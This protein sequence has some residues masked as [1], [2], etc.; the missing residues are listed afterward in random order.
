MRLS[1]RQ[2]TDENREAVLSLAVAEDQRRHIETTRECLAEAAEEPRWHPVAV[3]ADSTIVGFAMYG[4]F[5]GW[6]GADHSLQVWLDRLLIAEPYQ[7]KGYGRQAL[8]MLL[9]RLA[10]EYGCNDIF[11]SVYGDNER[12]IALYKRYGFRFTGEFDTKGESVMRCRWT[13]SG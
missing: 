8:V 10:D 7:G 5:P 4:A 1:I 9:D 13:R 12:A 2:V 11:L 3:Y 6:T